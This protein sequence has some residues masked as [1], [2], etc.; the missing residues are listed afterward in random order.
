MIRASFD[1][2][3]DRLER[4][5]RDESNGM[6]RFFVGIDGLP[7]SGKTA[8]A[9][10]L[11]RRLS[12]YVIHADDFSLPVSR[13]TRKR[14][15]TPG[16]EFD[17]E[18]F[19]REVVRPFLEKKLPTYSVFDPKTQSETGTVQVPAREIYI[20]EGNYV[21]H[22]EV[23]DLYDLRIVLRGDRET[24]LARLTDRGEPDPATRFDRV[25]EYLSAYLLWELSDVLVSG[26]SDGGDGGFSGFTL[27]LS[28]N[29]AN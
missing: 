6:A 11:A 26:E 9:E 20:M 4:L 8:L 10:E 15:E 3:P 24:A 19:T 28:L 17:Y 14:R 2:A 7:G 18:R 27:P 13:L 1:E 5:I 25:A 22:P 21:L 12:G 23:P 29:G 16:G